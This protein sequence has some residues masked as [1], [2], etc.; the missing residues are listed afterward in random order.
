MSA[1]PSA[2]LDFVASH[3]ITP[4]LP[5]LRRHPHAPRPRYPSLLGGH[6]S[7]EIGNVEHERGNLCWRLKKIRVQYG[8]VEF[9][10]FLAGLNLNIYEGSVS[11]GS[12]CSTRY[13]QQEERIEETWLTTLLGLTKLYGLNLAD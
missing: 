8:V 5:V 1:A 13:L 10:F 7:C 2:F 6:S 9:D 3:R 11:S 12:L 4:L